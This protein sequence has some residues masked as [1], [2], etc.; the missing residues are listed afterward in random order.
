[1]KL[2]WEQAFYRCFEGCGIVNPDGSDDSK[3]EFQGIPKE[4]Y[5]FAAVMTPVAVEDHKRN[6][7]DAASA[8]C[9]ARTQLRQKECAKTAEADAERA[10]S[11]SEWV[12]AKEKLDGKWNLLEPIIRMA[13]HDTI[14]VI[15]KKLKVPFVIGGSFPARHIFDAAAQVFD[16][17]TPIVQRQLVPQDIDVFHG[18]FTKA[19]LA[20]DMS[21]AQFARVTVQGCNWM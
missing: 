9:V 7:I 19:L 20:N 15:A 16:E 21:S 10:N 8:V 1:L 12:A 14:T 18:P 11:E 13:M 17:F 4:K 6:M 5:D 2:A 3:P